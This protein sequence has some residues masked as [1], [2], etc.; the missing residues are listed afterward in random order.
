MTQNKKLKIITMK[1][2]FYS[3]VAIALMFSC[4][5]QPQYKISGSIEGLNSGSA[6]L[7]KVVDNDLVTVDS[8]AVKDGMFAFE[9]TVEQPEIYIVSFADTLE[10]IQLFLENTEIQIVANLDSMGGAEVTGSP[11]TS[12]FNKFNT[13][14]LKYNMQFRTLYNEYIQA[15]MGGDA[16]RVKEIEEEYEEHLIE[17]AEK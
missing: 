4:T 17:I 15:N 9:G 14:L 16:A 10:E 7:S 3:L 13:E 1:K 8:V 12:S 11:L 2:L 5:K 6:V